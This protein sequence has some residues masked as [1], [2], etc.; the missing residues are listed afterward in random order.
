MD[1][2]GKKMVNVKDNH[3]LAGTIKKRIDYNEDTPNGTRSETEL[4][5][6]GIRIN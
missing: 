6:M 3:I 5:D 4:N 2:D 1:E